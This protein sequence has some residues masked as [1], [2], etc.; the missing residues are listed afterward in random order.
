[1]GVDELKPLE[2]AKVQTPT[3]MRKRL[4]IISIK[5]RMRSGTLS[6]D[7]VPVAPATPN[8]L[9]PRCSKEI[10]EPFVTVEARRYH[11]ECVTCTSCKSK[12]LESAFTFKDEIY[13]KKCY[14]HESSLICAE[15]DKPLMGDYLV[16]NDKK[17]HAACRKCSV[18]SSAIK[19]K[20]HAILGNAIFCADHKDSITCFVCQ[21][22]LEGDVVQVA[23]AHIV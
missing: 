21:K 9:C 3:S 22:K 16:I 12:I 8:S 2:T 18:C 17:Y 6:R 19:T 5:T 11:S 7:S 20:D 10:K 14:Y 23:I 1:V 13:C 4:S 15:C